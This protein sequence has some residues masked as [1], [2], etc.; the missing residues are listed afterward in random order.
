MKNK[1]IV[2]LFFIAIGF[3]ISG[4]LRDTLFLN[5]SRQINKTVNFHPLPEYLSFLNNF[6]AQELSILKSA[7]TLF[8]LATTL[9]LSTIFIKLFL[10]KKNQ[11]HFAYLFLALVILSGFIGGLY[12]LTGNHHLYSISKAIINALQSPLVAVIYYLSIKIN[13]KV[14]D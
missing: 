11:K 10:E 14:D 2:L 13:T 7:L 6:S 3:I 1:K 9:L 12:L 4:L 8:F 5:I